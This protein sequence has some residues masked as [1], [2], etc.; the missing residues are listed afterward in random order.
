MNDQKRLR[1]LSPL[2]SAFDSF[3]YATIGDDSNGLP[4]S[5][6]SALARLNIDPWEE[7]ATLTQL[8]ADTATR[9]LAALFMALPAGAAANSAPDVI[10][11]RLIAL[12]PRKGTASPTPASHSRDIPVVE[13]RSGTRM[14]AWLVIIVVLSAA[15]WLLVTH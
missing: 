15:Q 1:S 7:A 8:Q 2:G 13:P 6:N 4:L 14:I 10:A 5:V 9:R 12:L 3:L 11:A